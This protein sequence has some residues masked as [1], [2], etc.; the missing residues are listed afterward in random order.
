[1]T[2]LKDKV[3]LV[4]G[5]SQGVGAAIARAAVREGAKVA[6]TGRR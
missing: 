1:M 6:V 3:V 4:N 5:G 2:L